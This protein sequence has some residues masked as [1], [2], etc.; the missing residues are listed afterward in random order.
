MEDLR[1]EIKA[2]FNNLS[3]IDL[4]LI[5]YYLKN[6]NIGRV[7]EILREVKLNDQK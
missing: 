5:Q 6:N 7:K 2:V 3:V 1:K 4:G